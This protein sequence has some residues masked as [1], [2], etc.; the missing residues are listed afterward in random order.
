MF[1]TAPEN[2]HLRRATSSQWTATNPTLTQAEPAIE[3]DTGKFKVGDGM[4]P[5]VLLPYFTNEQEFIRMLR[6]QGP[7]GGP[8]QFVGGDAVTLD[9]LLAGILS[10]LASIDVGSDLGPIDGGDPYLDDP[11]SR[12]E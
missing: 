3:T 2:V 5:W 11:A 7:A 6:D 4:T 12:L 9:V 8:F 10:S 1:Y